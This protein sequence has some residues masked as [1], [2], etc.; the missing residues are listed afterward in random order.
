MVHVVPPP[1]G[2]NS[3]TGKPWTYADTSFKYLPT[4]GVCV[5]FVTLFSLTTLVHLFQAFRYRVFK[6][7]IPTVVMCGLVEIAGWSGRVWGA[8]NPWNDSAFTVQIVCTIFG[9][10]F[11]TAAF[12]IM[13][14]RIVRIVGEEYSRFSP[15]RYTRLFVGTD[16]FALLTQSVGGAMASGTSDATQIQNGTH[17]MVGGI[18]LQLVAITV[19]MLNSV[20]YFWRVKTERPIRSRSQFI[21]MA[22]RTDDPNTSGADRHKETGV[23]RMTPN[24]KKMI[25]GLIIAT[26]LVYV[27]SIYRTIELL[28]GWTGPII[29]DQ[30]LFDLFDGVPVFL[31]MITLNIYH[32]GRLIPVVPGL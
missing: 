3:D 10:S 16:V 23:E 4:F 5:L 1:S 13:Y 27:R 31:A 30:A 29:T 19:Y 2:I 24:V 6:W 7:W 18:I 9:P 8:V 21:S 11:M 20:E 14:V 32:P 12:F 28:D 26:I 15:R 22:S 17:V 25:K